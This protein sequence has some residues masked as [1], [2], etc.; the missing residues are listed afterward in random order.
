M[1]RTSQSSGTKRNGGGRKPKKGG[2]RVDE[3]SRRRRYTEM[4]QRQKKICWL[5]I[6]REQ[7]MNSVRL[8]V[9][10]D[11]Y[12][13]LYQDH[14]FPRK[15]HVCEQFM[16]IRKLFINNCLKKFEFQKV[17]CFL[18]S[19]ANLLTPSYRAAQCDPRN[20]F[21]SCLMCVAISIPTLPKM[22]CF[23]TSLNLWRN[24]TSQ[25]FISS[26]CP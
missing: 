19:L 22:G 15:C 21:K 13:F 7:L 18:Q 26:C 4:T 25:Y 6:F 2:K 11:V 23:V 14:L 5:N 24:T 10:L 1:K 17:M 9:Y 3:R 8:F 16:D 12:E 20:T